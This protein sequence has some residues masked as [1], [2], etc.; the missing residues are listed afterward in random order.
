VACLI[1]GK[2]AAPRVQVEFGEVE[3]WPH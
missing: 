2:S 3:S 1:V